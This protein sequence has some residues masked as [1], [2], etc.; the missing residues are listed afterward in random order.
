MTAVVEGTAALERLRD[1][2]D[3]EVRFDAG[4][5]AAY[6]TD[7]SNFRQVPLGVVTPRTVEAAVEAVAVC[8]ELGLPV[9]SRGGGTSLAGQGTNEAVV[10]DFSQH[11]HRLVS[12]DVENRRCVVEP[13]IV[14]DDL[15]RRLEPTG[16]RFGPSWR[17]TR[18]ARSAG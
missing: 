7:A 11:C 15:N 5:R 9:V 10:L 1:R 17:S 8:R 6:S 18:T 4:T 13:G 16:L 2:V 14:L 12:V 3:G